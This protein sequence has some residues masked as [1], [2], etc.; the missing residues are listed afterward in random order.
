MIEI[1]PYSENLGPYFESINKQW[2]EQYFVL[3]GI[4]H[5]VLHRHREYILDKGGYIFFALEDGVVV[6]T[7]ALKKETDG[8]FELTKMGVV[9][10]ARSKGIGQQLLRHC[11]DFARQR[12]IPKL[13][14]DSSRKLVNAIHIYHKIGFREIPVPSSEYARCDIRM[15][16]SLN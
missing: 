15:E 12:N 1:V 3:E 7:V 16:L 10:E 9:P 6:G 5:Q 4:D 13:F 14:L 2:I 11:I 8:L